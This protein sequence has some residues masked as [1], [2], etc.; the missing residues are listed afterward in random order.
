MRQLNL[1]HL[2][3]FRAIAHQGSLTGAAAQLHLSPSALS[4]Q[5]AKLEVQL[6]HPLFERRGKRLV[7]TEAGRLALDCADAVHDA[8]E[9]LLNR[10]RGHAATAQAL[11]VGALTTLSRNFQLQFLRPL[12][13]RED[14]ELVVRSGTLRELIAALDAHR[15]D[16]VLSSVELRRDAATTLHSHLLDEQRVA[17][18]SRPPPTG[19]PRTLRF[20][21]DLRSASVLLPS[22]E[23]DVRVA[24]DRTLAMAGIRPRIL[25]EV[26]DM[27][28][29]RVL[30]RESGALT[31]VPAIV[32]RDELEAGTLVERCAVPDVTERFFAIVQQRRFPNPLLDALL[33]RR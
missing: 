20:P 27:A 23:S 29:L 4:V 30:A 3:Y 7:L 13:G 11:R 16:V 1:H 15:L 25:A 21:E 5:L 10:L 26:D 2:R 12:I 8:G 24:F 18:V 33:P 17:L 14:V 19:R 32:V 22:L 6:G 31:L 28:M 9:E